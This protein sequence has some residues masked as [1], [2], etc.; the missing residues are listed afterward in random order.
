[1]CLR[2]RDD[3]GETAAVQVSVSNL[4]FAG[5]DGD[6]VWGVIEGGCGSGFCIGCNGWGIIRYIRSSSVAMMS[7]SAERV[8]RSLLFDFSSIRGK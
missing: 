8:R 4:F 6:H 1:M 7:S 5:D 3:E 2:K